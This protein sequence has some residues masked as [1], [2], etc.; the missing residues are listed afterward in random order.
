MN[1]YPNPANSYTV[2]EA[3]GL[4]EEMPADIFDIQGRKLKEYSMKADRKTLGKNL[5]DLPKGVYTIHAR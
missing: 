1:V 4:R 5:G 2:L 3:Q